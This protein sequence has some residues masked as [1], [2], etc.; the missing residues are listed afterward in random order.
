[1][2]KLVGE[3]PTKSECGTVFGEGRVVFLLA[4][5]NA[6][7][8]WTFLPFAFSLEVALPTPERDARETL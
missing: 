2:L 3:C 1:M 7:E 6:W 4:A 5:G 8:E